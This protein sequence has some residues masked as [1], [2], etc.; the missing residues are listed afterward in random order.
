MT[1]ALRE[2]ALSLR[3]Y[4][5]FA[6][7][8][9]ALWV[10]AIAAFG[11]PHYLLPSPAEALSALRDHAGGVASA[12]LFTLGCTAA[13]I[14][15]SVV[16]AMG[17]AVL[18]TLW[19]SLDHAL[20][21]LLIIIRAIPVIAVAPLLIMIWGRDQ[22]NTIGVVALLTFFQIMLAAKRGFLAPGANVI[23]MM[24]ANG[25]GFW[26]TLIKVRI[27]FATPYIFTGLRLAAHSAILSAMFAEWLS[28]AP[29]LGNLMLDAYSQQEFALMWGAIFV[30]T[31][32]AYLFFTLALVLER[33]VA[34]RSA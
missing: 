14:A 26:L 25:A 3:N 1:S 12:A 8:M 23:E 27:P 9:I 34:V 10:L 15:I 29:G 22:W 13:G 18:F 19:P 21:P 32:V 31:T 33:A 5:V 24:R 20:T 17:L 16:I 6:V 11:I 7:F 4:A 2:G 30:S 28:G